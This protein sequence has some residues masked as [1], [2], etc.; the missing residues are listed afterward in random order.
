M[1]SQT[2][3]A[4]PPTNTG[5][6]AKNFDGSAP[7]QLFDG[8]VPNFAHTSGVLPALQQD[9]DV[10]WAWPRLGIGESLS[11]RQ[12]FVASRA[13]TTTLDTLGISTPTETTPG[14]AKVLTNV[15]AD[16]Y[17]ITYRTSAVIGSVASVDTFSS[18][19]MRRE[20]RPAF[21]AVVDTPATI[22]SMRL[23]AG[24]FSS[25]PS[26]ADDP[27]THGIGFRY[28]TNAVTGQNAWIGWANDGVG[29]GGIVTNTNT[30]AASTR[31]E[32]SFFCPTTGVVLFFLNGLYF[33]GLSSGLPTSTQPLSLYCG[34]TALAA[35]A[36]TFTMIRLAGHSA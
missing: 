23:W 7:T 19:F 30:V 11:R 31:Y 14:A 21:T 35:S 20:M 10:Q 9:V 26:A 15:G 18:G 13:N 29:G 8:M 22:T 3:G 33:G 27:T 24:L 32:L 6:L 25:T 36:R 1:S 5:D 4:A 16:G 28:T 2:I 17:G 12:W 34:I